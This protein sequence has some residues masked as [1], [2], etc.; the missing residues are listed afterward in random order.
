LLRTSDILS[1]A[2]GLY[3]AI[4]AV[5]PRW[6]W[7]RRIAAW[8]CATGM[9]GIPLVL[10]ALVPWPSVALARDWAPAVYILISY[11]ASGTLFVGPSAR[12]EAWLA[13]ADSWLPLMSRLARLPPSLEAVVEVLYAGTFLVI[14]AGFAVLVAYG[15]RAQAD[16]YWT[17]V[18]IAEYVSFGLLPWL[19]SR[20][21]WLVEQLNPDH[22]RGIRKAGLLWVRR[23]SHCANTFP[24]GHTA[25]S[26]T[27]ALVVMP[28]APVPGILLLAVAIGIAIGCVAGRYHYAVDVVAGA[29]L[30]MAIAWIG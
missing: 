12:F 1:C 7:R 23:T 19:P 2:F 18:S 16:R 26:L 17:M 5:L 30:A 27:I 20:P 13:R 10:A 25:G 21:P 9:I 6:G 15:F 22:S 24:S 11:Y 4:T 3:I 28:F 14:P 29:A 8:I